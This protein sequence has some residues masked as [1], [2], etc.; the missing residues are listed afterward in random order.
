MCTY[1]INRPVYSG[2]QVSV[3][4]TA[5]SCLTNS[6]DKRQCRGVNDSVPS[7]HKSDPKI[8]ASR[9]KVCEGGENC[10]SLPS[11]DSPKYM[12]SAIRSDRNGAPF[13]RGAQPGSATSTSASASRTHNTR[14]RGSADQRRCEMTDVSANLTAFTAGVERFAISAPNDVRD[15]ALGRSHVVTVDQAGVQDT[16]GSTVRKRQDFVGA[17]QQVTVR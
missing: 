9:G 6:R 12:R 7:T 11:G 1:L 15:H 8:Q 14:S 2:V 10:G 16:E 17:D 5:H 13:I 3:L 4:K